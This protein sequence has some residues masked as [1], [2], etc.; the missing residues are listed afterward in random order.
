[1]GVCDVGVCDVGVCVLNRL[2][3]TLHLLLSEGYVGDL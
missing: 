2:L 3:I 1:M